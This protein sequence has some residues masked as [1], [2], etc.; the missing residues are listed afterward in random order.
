MRRA[1]EID[2]LGQGRCGSYTPTRP[3][4]SPSRA[5]GRSIALAVQ[6]RWNRLMRPLRL[7]SLVLALAG[8][9]PSVQT[10]QSDLGVHTDSAVPQRDLSAASD[11]GDPQ[12]ACMDFVSAVC[13]SVQRCAP[14]LVMLAYGDVATCEQRV[15][16]SCATQAL[17][18]SQVT[19]QYYEACAGAYPNISCDDYFAGKP[20]AAC[21]APAGTLAAGSACGSDV[22]C[23]TS[24]CAK[25]AGASCGT[26][27]PPLQAGEACVTSSGCGA[28]SIC[29]KGLC[30][31][32]GVLGD[33]CDANTPCAY[34]L[35]CVTAQGAASGTCTRTSELGEV[36]DPMLQTA[37]GCD[38]A[39]G[40]YCA[41]LTHQC[42]AVGFAQPGAICGTSGS[43][44][45]LCQAGGRCAYGDGGTT[46][47]CVAPAADGAQCAVSPAVPG[48]LAP[49]ACTNGLCVIADPSQC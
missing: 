10:A 32:I 42:V 39:N 17:N 14:A 1:A 47:T 15:S 12:Q 26:C 7:A 29:F 49:A 8:C 4:L 2:K 22:Q 11:L 34:N 24:Y 6:L 38:A 37:P 21:I 43:I 40:V 9:A 35:S 18:G 36:C 23:S 27:A 28:G 44:I 33:S 25:M 48:C 19:S 31:K 45:T 30:A 16:L 5:G 13:A 41:S 3:G 20:P 46:G